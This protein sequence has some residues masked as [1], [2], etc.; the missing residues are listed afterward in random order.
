MS[1]HPFSPIQPSGLSDQVI[2]QIRAAIIAGR[3][4]PGDH[5]VEAA[6]T[7]Q[8]QVSRTPLREALAI[9]EHEGLVLSFPNRGFFVRTFTEKDVEELFSLRTALEN[10]AGSLT[11]GHLQ[12][13]DF[14]SLSGLIAMQRTA[15]L[16]GDL[17]QMRAVDMNF[18][19]YLVSL[20]GHRLLLQSWQVLVA[21]IAALL[22][23]RAETI[24]S[25]ESM[26][27]DDHARTLQLYR[28]KDRQGL[29]ALNELINQRV[30]DECL[31]ALHIWNAQSNY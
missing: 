6:L 17:E 9:L 22:C 14:E 31:R 28:D 19:R 3:L 26:A 7:R 5:I 2:A 16:Q 30:K 11:I 10:F 21:Q 8:L 27:L 20:P 29:F 15:L 13:Q 12:P 24:D 25:D 23:I 18:H 4:K 1:E